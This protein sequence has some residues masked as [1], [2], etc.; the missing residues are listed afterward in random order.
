[1]SE[2][3]G[4]LDGIK[5]S[6]D[7]LHR[8]FWQDILSGGI[9]AL[10]GTFSAF[11]LGVYSQRKIQRKSLLTN[12]RPAAIKDYRK[13]C[14]APLAGRPYVAVD[15]ATGYSRPNQLFLPLQLDLSDLS[16]LWGRDR[17]ATE[18]LRK[19][20]EKYNKQVVVLF[21]KLCLKAQE[22]CKTFV[23]EENLRT[24]L[25]NSLL[26]I[27]EPNNWPYIQYVLDSESGK[28]IKSLYSEVKSSYEQFIGL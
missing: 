10:L 2:I 1:M 14:E 18:Q 22:D 8:S 6:I 19:S 24:I 9:G 28:E 23:Q 4:A 5:N 21:K 12:L 16:A 26:Q 3:L 27:K 25:A 7:A 17:E 11:I 13:I 15:F 20:I